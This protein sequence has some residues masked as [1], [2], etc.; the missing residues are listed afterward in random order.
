VS[1]RIRQR[2]LRRCA[3]V[4]VGV[5]G[6]LPQG[7]FASSSPSPSLSLAQPPAKVCV[8]SPAP[9]SPAP[10]PPLPPPLPP[11]MKLSFMSAAAFSPYSRSRLRRTVRTGQPN[12]A[13]AG[14]RESSLTLEL[15]P[16]RR[17]EL[18][19]FF[20]KIITFLVFCTFFALFGMTVFVQRGERG[21]LCLIALL[22]RNTSASG[23]GAHRL[24]E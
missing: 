4:D 1:S 3:R 18:E 9:E 12:G 16:L 22:R 20:E 19:V 21:A 14:S 17:L 8:P 24:D 11:L 7:I 2:Q 10:P 15:S 23:R 13:M 5:H 6:H